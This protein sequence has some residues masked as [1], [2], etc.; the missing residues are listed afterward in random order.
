[1]ADI[2]A[3]FEE[4]AIAAD[5]AI[6]TPQV[7][8][9]PK[10]RRWLRLAIMLIVPLLIAAGGAYVWLTS[11]G[12]VST[13]N[14]YVQQDKVS[15]ASEIGGR[16]VEV[17][18][19]ENE[20]VKAGDILFRIDPAP[21]RLAV[22]AADA[23]IADAQVQVDTLGATA[24]S[25]SVD[26]GAARE[27]I[28]YAET[29]FERQQQLMDRGFTTRAD[30]D[31]ARHAVQQA[32]ER[33]NQAQADAREANSRLA[34]GSALPGQNPQIAAAKV[35]KEQAQYNLDRTVVRAP[36]GGRV[37]QS[38]RL[39]VGQQMVAGLPALTVV[40]DGRSWIEANFKET[41]LENMRVGQ[42]A[43]IRMDAYPDVALKGHVASI[44]AGTGS[45]MSVLPAQNATGNW[46]KVTQRIPVRIAIDG[47]SARQLIAGMSVDVT[48]D[49]S[50]AEH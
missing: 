37:T 18:A 39:M 10:R 6:E 3:A 16:I 14:A 33:L 26:I 30:Y 21:Y 7:Q 34:T 8:A 11:G 23:S 20:N 22:A 29:I 42:P 15:V 9:P 41:D 50:S 17:N 36:L 4:E 27:D 1:M 31:T 25:S 43:E 12:S 49:T 24:Q 19:R 28:A 2:A 45:E 32:K 13:D 44:G 35:R 46:V 40:A 48:I 38:D 47:K 5:A